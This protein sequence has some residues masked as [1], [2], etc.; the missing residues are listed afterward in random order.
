MSLMLLRLVIIIRINISITHILYIRLKPAPP[1]APCIVAIF[2][3]LLSQYFA[4]ANE[5]QLLIMFL[6]LAGQYFMP[7]LLLLASTYIIIFLQINTGQTISFNF[8]VYK[9]RTLSPVDFICRC[10][11]VSFGLCFI[12]F[13]YASVILFR[14][15]SDEM[16]WSL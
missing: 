7:G 4:Y 13:F 11:C 1:V 12:F 16:N 5:P 6:W 15:F 3:Y 10:C 9:T 8:T 2:H 14:T